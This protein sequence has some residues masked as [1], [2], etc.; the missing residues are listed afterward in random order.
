MIICSCNVITDTDVR[1]AVS[2]AAPRTAGQVYGC[3]GCSPQCGRCAR[4][5]KRIMDEALGSAACPV[6][7]CCAGCE[8]A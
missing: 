3:L 8:T 4:T 1:D 7:C 5:I 6:G 2:E